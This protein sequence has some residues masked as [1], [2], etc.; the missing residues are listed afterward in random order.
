MVLLLPSPPVTRPVV[1]R[2]KHLA[3]PLVPTKD[4]KPHERSS[5]RKHT[6][7]KEQM[8][9]EKRGKTVNPSSGDNPWPAR[10]T[11]VAKPNKRQRFGIY[12]SLFLAILGLHH[13]EK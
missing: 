4:E 8:V 7:K 3:D 6:S 1:T 13:S 10:M 5:G 11:D 9:E 2:V 12:S